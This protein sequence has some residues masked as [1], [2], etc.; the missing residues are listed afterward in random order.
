[1]IKTV[2]SKVDKKY[3]EAFRK[4]YAGWDIV[5]LEDHSLLFISPNGKVI[6]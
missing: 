3:F 2:L 5:R 6:K 1:M 4:R